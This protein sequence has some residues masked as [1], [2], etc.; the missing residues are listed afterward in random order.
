MLE[1]VVVAARV[2]G[3][4]APAGRHQL[5]S[6][7]AEM[8]GHAGRG[9][10]LF[11]LKCQGSR[12]EILCAI[13]IRHRDD[14]A[15]DAIDHGLGMGLKRGEEEPAEKCHGAFHRTALRAPRRSR[16]WSPTRNALAMI[17]S[18]GFTAALETKKLPS[19]T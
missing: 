6:L 10:A 19:T 15:A 5:D 13:E 18:V 3:Q 9:G 8:H 1:P 4:F 17:V 12:I 2:G 16:R 11:R 7:G 14:D